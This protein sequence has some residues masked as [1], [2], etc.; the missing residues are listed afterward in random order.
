VQTYN[1]II[2]KDGRETTQH[3]SF[4]FPLVIYTT[5]INKNIL[6]YIDW[7]WHEELQFCVVTKGSVQFT[8]NTE[9][10]QLKKGEGLF[11]NKGNLHKAENSPNTDSSYLCFN[12][13]PDLISGFAGSILNTK[14]ILPYIENP[15]IQY[16]ILKTR[17]KWQA[18]ILKK[19][20]SIYKTYTPA[21]AGS[22][23]QIFILLLEIWHILVR[24]YFVSFPKSMSFE[25]NDRIKKAMGYIEQHYMKKI[26]LSN[27]AGEVGLSQSACCREFKRFMQ[28]TIFEYITNYR[29][30]MSTK[31][32]LTTNQSISD[33]AYQCGFGSPSYYIER[34]KK[35]TGVSPFAY[36][37]KNT[38]I[39]KQ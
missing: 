16:C 26:L 36:R 24:L 18:A 6:G 2:D 39:P 21:G 28:C 25:N 8:I 22:E 19:L 4:E 3:G 17:V 32:L 27:I 31:L 13:H 34:F 9:I 10:I 15:S 12:F 29:L 1:I 33:I 37:S 11:I 7:H 5:Q 35:R 30:V 20:L 23:L 14:Y 38:P